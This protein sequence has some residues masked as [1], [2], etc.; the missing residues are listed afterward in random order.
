MTA[1]GQTLPTVQAA[2]SA[3]MADVRAVAKKDRNTSQGGGF[4]FRGIDA[5]VNAVGPALRTHGV[6]VTPHLDQIERREGRTS[7]GGTLNYVAVVVT[8]TF[9]GPA[10]DTM[11]ATV[12]GEAFD[13]GDK[14]TAKAMSVAFR[15]CLLQALALPTDEA[16]PDADT[17]EATAV[18]AQGHVYGGG[19]GPQD[20]PPPPP[21]QGQAPAPEMDVQRAM[22]DAWNNPTTLESLGSWL[23]NNNVRPAGHPDLVSIGNRIRELKGAHRG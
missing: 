13:S 11:T 18:H 6:V 22:R 21:H 16:D 14:A 23:Y 8:Y 17:Y 4:L 7:K 10:G 9:T 3:V 20:A 12:P 5:V 15:T 2:V 19:Q 1:D